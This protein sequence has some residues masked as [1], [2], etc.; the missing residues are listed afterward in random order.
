MIG[1]YR[2]VLAAFAVVAALGGQARAQDNFD[3]GKTPAQLYASDC[4][5]CHKS[6]QGMTQA[7]GIFGLAGFL[8]QHYT[9]S[10]EAAA[11]IAT[12]VQSIDKGPAA[13]AK[14]ASSKRSRQARRQGQASEAKS[15]QAK[16]GEAKSGESQARVR[17]RLETP[18]LRRHQVRRQQAFRYQ[19]LR[20]QGVGAQGVRSQS[21]R[22]QVRG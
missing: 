2:G 13:P 16:S 20:S 12:Y 15:G 22:A 17:P 5:I 10:R 18:R 14:R 1:F 9:A 4:A 11:A 19:A 7:G 21:L 6:A 3:A 8:R